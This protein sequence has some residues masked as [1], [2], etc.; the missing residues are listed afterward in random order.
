MSRISFWEN[1]LTAGPEKLPGVF[2]ALADLE[3]RLQ[4]KRL[5]AIAAPAPIYVSGLARAG[6]TALIHMLG[7]HPA[8]GT[9]VA[10]D[11][12]GIFTP[13]WWNRLL[14]R[15]ARLDA[16]PAERV[17]GD[18]ILVDAQ[19]PEAVEEVL[20]L[21]A[22]GQYDAAFAQTLRHHQKKILLLRQRTRYAAKANG[23][24]GRL[25]DVLRMMPDA[26]IIIPVRHPV[27]HVASLVRQHA[28]FSAIQKKDARARKAMRRLGHFEF[29]LDRKPG[30]CGNAETARQVAAAF[31]S[32]DDATGYALQWQGAYGAVM[33]LRAGDRR[34]AD[35]THL[36]RHEDMTAS[37]AETLLRILEFVGLEPPSGFVA[38][39][40]SRLA[41]HTASAPPL[42]AK[43]AARVLALTA[44]TRAL[45]G[46][47]VG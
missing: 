10:A 14:P 24:L 19:S 44:E 28:H 23:H 40:A 20:W 11:F 27:A 43:E 18:G 8:I 30:F 21:A 2:F 22:R 42:G 17:H 3:D 35:A 1:M 29:G 38:S 41:G 4:A 25:A 34:I 47:G 32:G 12:P 15:V 16:P 31:A 39:E 45:A 26:R 36:V 6:T 33:R 13:I 7:R 46:Y 5:S 9:H 37:P